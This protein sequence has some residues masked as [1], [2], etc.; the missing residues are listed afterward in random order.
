MTASRRDSNASSEC[1]DHSY[2]S[3]STAPT[4]YSHKP[5][6]K[7][8]ETDLS[9]FKANRIWEDA[10]GEELDSRLSVDSYASTIA[11]QE[12]PE[13]VEACYEEPEEI[14]YEPS[15]SPAFASTPSEFAEYFPSTRRLNIRH[16]DTIDGNMNLRVDTETRT[17][18]GRK[19]DLIL[20][21]LRMHDLKRRE[22]SLRRYCRDSGKEIC[23]SNRKYTKPA[24]QRRPTLRHSLSSALAS[25]RGKSTDK[26]SIKSLR[27]HDS[28]YGS[29]NG[30]DES[31]AYDETQPTPSKNLPLPT[32]T[33]TLEFS[34]YAH[35]E[36]KRRG[37]KSSKRYDFD[38]WGT[39]YS[40]H[41]SLKKHGSSHQTS[42]SL[43]AARSSTPVAHIVPELMSPFEAEEEE[44]KGGWIPPSSMWISDSKI[45]KAQTDVAE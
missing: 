38:F 28:G 43:F 7:H 1:S 45:L 8:F 4:D 10:T 25:F 19:V 12:D 26:A 14:Y 11:S 24:S 41:R 15:T 17:G 35:V 31:E 36:I 30:D 27:R 34:N 22:F 29:V 33:T 42:Y 6:L 37:T 40:W 32:N 16:D 18:S 3:R 13:E 23:K 39:S 9:R 44:R 2:H 20:F 5:S 21:H